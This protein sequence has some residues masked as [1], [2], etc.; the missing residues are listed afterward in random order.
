MKLIVGLGNPGPQYETTRHNIGFLCADYLADALGFRGP[1]IKEKAEVWQGIIQTSD[2]SE[3]TMIIK[4]QTFMNLSG[5]S[6]GPLFSFYKCEPKDLIVI[7]DELDINPLEIRFKKGGSSGGHNGIKSIDDALGSDKTDYTRVRLGIGHPRAQNMRMD[8]S[9]YVLGKIPDNQWDQLGDL[10]K[11]TE[12]GIKL[13][14]NNKM[15]EAM[16]RFH[17][18][19]N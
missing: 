2:G 14:L 19:P 3:Q 16:R 10:F 18:K 7:Y 6:V 11:R 17:Q 9:D 13:I 8:V 5:R 12:E 4:P 15:D 1:T